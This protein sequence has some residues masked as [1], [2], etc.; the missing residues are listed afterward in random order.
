MP[1]RPLTP[2]A[3]HHWSDLD[4]ELFIDGIKAAQPID[5]LVTT[6]GRGPAALRKRALLMLPTDNPADTTAAIAALY[7]IL[8]NQP[9]YDW[10][11]AVRAR[12]SAEGQA[13]WPDATLTALDHMW[14][15]ADPTLPQFATQ[16]GLTEVQIAT[17]LIRTH[18]TTVVEIVDRLGCTTHGPLHERYRAAISRT[19]EAL[20][21]ATAIPLEGKLAGWTQLLPTRE[22]A[23]EALHTILVPATTPD[24]IA[25][26]WVIAQRICGQLTTSNTQTGTGATLRKL[27]TN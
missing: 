16:H 9:D 12:L 22:A 11:G 15:H 25:V 23:K 3:G 27:L 7:E 24:A 4:Y 26:R 20:W 5:E 2:R 1:K 6:L 10:R 18:D 13:Y 8:T 14:T 21:I 17:R 19:T